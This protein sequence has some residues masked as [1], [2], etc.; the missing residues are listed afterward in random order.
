[1]PWSNVRGV[2]LVCIHYTTHLTGAVVCVVLQCMCVFVHVFAYVSDSVH[3]YTYTCRNVC[4][5]LILMVTGQMGTV[6]YSTHMDTHTPP[7]P[8]QVTHLSASTSQW[9][10]QATETDTTKEVHRSRD[11]CPQQWP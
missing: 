2:S 8:M 3:V 7:S 5:S 6:T 10:G 1:M 4:C 11:I 9:R